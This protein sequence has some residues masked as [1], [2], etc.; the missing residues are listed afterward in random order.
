MYSDDKKHLRSTRLYSKF[1]SSS[2]ILNLYALGWHE[3][4]LMYSV[5]QEIWLSIYYAQGT[6]LGI[7]VKAVKETSCSQNLHAGWRKANKQSDY[8][9]WLVY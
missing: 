6:V 2:V 3:H 5:S 4:I 7:E 9:W 1:P 8:S